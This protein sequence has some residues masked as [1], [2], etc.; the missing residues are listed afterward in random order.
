[1]V[2]LVQAAKRQARLVQRLGPG[3]TLEFGEVARAKLQ[4]V[5]E[6]AFGYDQPSVHVEFAERQAPD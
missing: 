4:E 6:V 5:V 1:M 3:L 2:A